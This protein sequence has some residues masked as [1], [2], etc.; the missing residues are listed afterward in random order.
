MPSAYPVC[1]HDHD[2]NYL[3]TT[4]GLYPDLISPLDYNNRA[5]LISGNLRALWF[6]ISLNEN[7]KGGSYPTKISTSN[8]IT[9]KD[10]V[11]A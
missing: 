1:P 11:I 6:D 7:T 4:P 10:A 8:L 2:E 3:R 9:A 5:T